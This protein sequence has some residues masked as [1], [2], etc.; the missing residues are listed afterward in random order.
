M[1]RIS[2]MITL[3]AITLLCI[4]CERESEEFTVTLDYNCL[5]KIETMIV[6]TGE[7]IPIPKSGISPA[8]QE[9]D[10]WWIVEGGV[11]RRWDFATDV[12]TTDIQLQQ[13]WDTKKA[14]IQ[15]Y[16]SDE[17][18]TPELFEVKYGE[19]YTIPQPTREE[20]YFAGWYQ[21][22][23][24]RDDSGIWYGEEDTFYV[25]K[26][27]RVPLGT[28]V[29][30]GAYE[31]DDDQS[32]DKEPIEWLV[33]DKTDTSY[34]LVSS[35]LLDWQAYHTNQAGSTWKSSSLRVW[36]NDTFYTTAFNN[37]ERNHICLTA[38]ADVDC[39]DYIFLLN[40]Q[41][42]N[43]LIEGKYLA[44]QMTEY[45]LEVRGDTTTILTGTVGGYK[46]YEYWLR[47]T[48]NKS[49][50]PSTLGNSCKT[51]NSSRAGVRP[52]MWVDA[53]YVETLLAK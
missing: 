30:L 25:A 45:A 32:N 11:S 12:V 53:A 3:L 35:A 43:M 39:N 42:K 19:P 49:V 34:L 13:R 4:G 44:G 41:E 37:A 48:N 21:G 47:C 23:T 18:N 40:E 27:T 7:L 6:S 16:H 31:Q 14:Y 51:S 5:G 20:W 33:I 9:S 36:L 15:L 52:A 2:V 46:S 24:R 38:L 26:W 10:G 29:M 50:S 8:G 17:D 22:T 1:K 28:T